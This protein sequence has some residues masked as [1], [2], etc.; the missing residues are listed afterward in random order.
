MAD[1]IYGFDVKDRASVENWRKQAQT[2]NERAAKAVDEA[3][4]ILKEFKQTAEGQVFDEVCSYGDGIIT[5]M[6]QIVSGMNDI[7]EAVNNLMTNI[8][9]AISNMVGGVSDKRNSTLGN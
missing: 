6:T 1:N 4:Q 9:D 2:L 7:L 8:I 5:G 3:A